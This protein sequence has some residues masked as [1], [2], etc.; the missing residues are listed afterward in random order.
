MFNNL[1]LTSK[2]VVSIN[3]VFERKIEDIELITK[4][5]KE[6]GEEPDPISGDIIKVYE[7]VALE[8]EKVYLEFKFTESVNLI[9]IGEFGEFRVEE[10]S[11][12][13]YNNNIAKAKL[14]FALQYYK[15]K[16]YKDLIGKT[17]SLVVIE[18]EFKGKE[19]R[20]IEFALRKV[21]KEIKK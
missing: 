6:I 10:K 21:K 1:G 8:E 11:L 9:A 20:N 7:E 3:K 17:I 5:K 18:S 12:R 15:C 14:G 2:T 19:Y 4:V 13:V 16:E